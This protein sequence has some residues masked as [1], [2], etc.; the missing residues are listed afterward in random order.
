M[1]CCTLDYS[2]VIHIENRFL[3]AHLK[4][5]YQHLG[6]GN[7][8]IHAS[9]STMPTDMG[10]QKKKKKEDKRRLVYMINLPGNEENILKKT[11]PE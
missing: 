6:G 11:D 8:C 9:E 5:S 4:Y 1:K 2:I 3:A 7:S 10:S